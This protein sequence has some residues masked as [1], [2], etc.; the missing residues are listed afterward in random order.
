MNNTEAE[1]LALPIDRKLEMATTLRKY[2]LWGDAERLLANKPIGST[3]ISVLMS[4]MSSVIPLD[5]IREI[6]N[7]HKR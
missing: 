4:E 2:G 5:A 3:G 6:V 1:I 7:R